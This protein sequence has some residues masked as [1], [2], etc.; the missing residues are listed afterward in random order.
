MNSVDLRT[1][2]PPS[3]WSIDEAPAPSAQA[4]SLL[5]AWL[6]TPGS[7]AWLALAA[8]SRA[9]LDETRL[10]VVVRTHGLLSTLGGITLRL[11]ALHL[12]WERA[13]AGT[14]GDYLQPALL[15]ADPIGESL[16]G[17]F[18]SVLAGVDDALTVDRSR[19]RQI[20]GATVVCG[21]YGRLI[22]QIRAVQASA[23]RPVAS[24]KQAIQEYAASTG[25]VEPEYRYVGQSGPSH[26]C[27]HAAEVRCD[28]RV[29]GPAMGATKRSAEDAAARLWLEAHAAHW[30]SKSR[31]RPRQ[32]G[33]LVPLAQHARAVRLIGEKLSLPPASDGWLSAVLADRAAA[34]TPAQHGAAASGL[35]QLGAEVLAVGV[36]C[37][38]ACETAEGRMVGD[39]HLIR[40][41]LLS[42]DRLAEH[43]RRSQLGVAYVP[44][45]AGVVA[46][47]Q[48]DAV[49]GVAAVTLLGEVDPSHA[50][51]VLLPVGIDLRSDLRARSTQGK[52]ELLHPK[53]ALQELAVSLGLNTEY[54]LVKTR[55]PA[56]AAEHRSRVTL[57]A[58]S[59]KRLPVLS[60][61]AESRSSAERRISRL[62]L[63]TLALEPAV[64]HDNAA[65]QIAAFVLREGAEYLC[66]EP[67]FRMRRPPTFFS[68][69]RAWHKKDWIGVSTWLERCELLTDTETQEVWANLLTRNIERGG[70]IGDPAVAKMLQSV[71]EVVSEDGL[72]ESQPVLG[73]ELEER[74][75]NLS[76][77]LSLFSRPRRRRSVAEIVEEIQLLQS[78]R[79]RLQISGGSTSEIIE[80]VGA[81]A[82]LIN[83][84][85]RRL[86]NGDVEWRLDVS[87]KSRV[88]VLSI[89]ASRPIGEGAV[90]PFETLLR[91]DMPLVGLHTMNN[92]MELTW[93]SDPPAAL[94]L[95]LVSGDPMPV[96]ETLASRL[97][98]FKNALSAHDAALSRPAATA[99]D[100]FRSQYEASSHLD[101]AREISQLVVSSGGLRAIV[102]DDQVLDLAAFLGGYVTQLVARRQPN[103]AVEVPVFPAIEVNTSPS[104]LRIVL[105]NLVK[106]AEEAMP[107]GGHLAVSLRTS[108]TLGICVTD[109]G[110][111]IEPEI[112]ER[113]RSGRAAPSTKRGGSGLGLATVLTVAR[114]LGAR[115]EVDSRPGATVM[116]LEMEPQ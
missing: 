93:I 108:P 104:L 60:P 43:L 23:S 92:G 54:G 72:E 38:Q 35:A 81:T 61:W 73:G 48:A 84:V 106:N 32:T 45:L 30:L 88:V 68:L 69:F 89:S 82:A 11:L 87:Q 37:A 85:L 113:I 98:D 10:G 53:M 46:R 99:T 27:T 20:V 2:V 103:V 44:G 29:A 97:H 109:T 107:D 90:F 79:H 19:L 1:D 12:T 39:T 18:A 47:R 86:P 101:A 24:Y 102:D 116:F 114:R 17:A 75:L 80:R 26:N 64:L 51:G 115:L 67:S 83:A 16:S 28:G 105:D 40:H 6:N 25:I 59:G 58:A 13:P 36:L 15:L 62:V 110:G 56:H 4:G 63:R 71:V 76:D 9:D 111:G 22:D 42:P 94:D 14:S 77:L 66:G 41:E 91:R 50:A 31:P 3:P 100:R 21:A 65:R 112:V 74:L 33:Q 7:S 49:Q 5:S 70:P 8:T 34:I 96:A 95:V 78:H 52:D 55:G 57:V